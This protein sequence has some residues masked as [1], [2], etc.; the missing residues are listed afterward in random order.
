LTDLAVWP[1]PHTK[2]IWELKNLQDCW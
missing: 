1:I 2:L